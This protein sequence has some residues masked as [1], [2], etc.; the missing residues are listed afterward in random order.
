ML[1]R[2]VLY[3]AG[4]RVETERKPSLGVALIVVGIDPSRNGENVTSPKLWTILEKKTNPATEKK[5]GQISFP[6]ETGKT[7]ENLRQNIFGAL[8]EEFSGDDQ[9]TDNLWYIPGYSHVEGKVLISGRP[10]DL[11]ILTFTGDLDSQN[12]PLAK[13]EVSPHRWMTIEEILNEHPDRIRKFAREIALIDQSERLVGKLVSEFSH[14]PLSRRPILAFAPDNFVSM[15]QFYQERKG[16]ENI[17]VSSIPL[18][19]S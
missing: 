4:I 6:G 13:D 15:R 7:G 3:P 5:A 12:L 17:V 8:A 18:K 1:G 14:N 11:I 10:A 16:R 9:K 19:N 2:E